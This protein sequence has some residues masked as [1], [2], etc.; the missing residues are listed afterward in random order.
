MSEVLL[1]N[2]FHIAVEPMQQLLMVNFSKDY[3]DYY[4]GLELQV[5]KHTK[6]EESFVVVGW[7]R[8]GKVD[9]YFEVYSN[10]R[11]KDYNHTGK[12]LCE[13]IKTT[14]STAH[15][16]VDSKGIRAE[17]QFVDKYGRKISIDISENNMNDCQPFSLLAPMG[18]ASK[19]PTSFPLLLFY[20]FYF[21][22]K[23]GSKLEVIIAGR[24]HKLDMLPI[25]VD[26]SRMT[27]TRYCSKPLI[28][29]LN[30]TLD[31][32]LGVI[33]LKNS[34]KEITA[35]DSIL[36]IYWKNSIPSLK[37]VTQLNSVYPIAL[38]FSPPFPNIANLKMNELLEGSFSISSHPSVGK[39]TGSYSVIRKENE[40]KIKCSPIY[41]WQPAEKKWELNTLYKIAPIFTQWPKTYEWTGYITERNK[42]NYYMH[43]KWKRKYIN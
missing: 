30:P 13:K 24:K 20:D 23:K 21:V 17:F 32:Y 27:F 28:A 26:G 35:G 11:D 10:V 41:G 18:M 4:I 37:Q 43:S 38:T 7:R 14:I 33:K 12:G 2:P 5:F 1:I 3:D 8:D 25:P 19:Q 29:F 16:K 9:V 15:F 22:R 6:T 31:D 40:I 42:I 36:M 34:Q 39:I